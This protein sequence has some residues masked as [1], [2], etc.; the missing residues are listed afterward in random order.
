MAER[1]TVGDFSRA[2]QLTIKTLRHYHEVGLLEPAEVDHKTSYR[3]YAPSQ[4][5]QAQAIRR[6]RDL[7]M[8]VADVKAVLAAPTAEAR[9]ALI[10]KH[11]ERLESELAR[12]RR[13]RVAGVSIALSAFAR[14]GRGP[15]CSRVSPVCGEPS[16][17]SAVRTSAGDSARFA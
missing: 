3:Y 5:P 6:L 15:M 14:S 12:T 17:P 4:I 9:S 16:A 1:L 2:T 8:P 13:D 7:D 10:G 11:L